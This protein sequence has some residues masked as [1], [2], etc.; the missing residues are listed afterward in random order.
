LRDKDLLRDFEEAD[1]EVYNSLQTNLG[2]A[3]AEVGQLE[4]TP[5]MHQLL[6]H[7]RAATTQVEERSQGTASRYQASIPGVGQHDHA[8]TAITTPTRPSSP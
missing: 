2:A 8:A 4:D 7:I 6:A 1:L 3:L 5:A